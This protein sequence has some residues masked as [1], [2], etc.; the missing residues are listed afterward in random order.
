MRDKLR[1]LYDVKYD[2]GEVE[3]NVPLEMIQIVPSS[4]GRNDRNSVDA[5][6]AASSNAHTMKSQAHASQNQSSYAVEQEFFSPINPSHRPASGPAF[7]PASGASSSSSGP[8]AAP[9]S[10][11]RPSHTQSNPRARSA[12]SSSAG[13]GNDRLG[14]APEYT[15]NM[16]TDG[17][18]MSTRGTHLHEFWDNRD[19]ERD[20]ERAPVSFTGGGEILMNS[21]LNDMSALQLTLD[22]EAVTLRRAMNIVDSRR[23]YTD[24]LSTVS[25]LSAPEVIRASTSGSI[26]PRK[27]FGNDGKEQVL[28]SAFQD[29]AGLSSHVGTLPDLRSARNSSVGSFTPQAWKHVGGAANVHNSLFLSNTAPHPTAQSHAHLQQSGVASQSQP[30]KPE[31]DVFVSQSLAD[32]FNR[33]NA[34]STTTTP[35]AYGGAASVGGNISSSAATGNV[36]RMTYA[37]VA[38]VRVLAESK[39][40]NTVKT[41]ASTVATATREGGLDELLQVLAACGYE[42][43][44]S[45]GG[46]FLTL[47]QSCCTADPAG[48]LQQH[49]S[50]GSSSSGTAAP[51]SGHCQKLL[52]KFLELA[53]QGQAVRDVRAKYQF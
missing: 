29:S 47:S 51:R 23:V 14:S 1:G 8:R 13:A 28:Y 36:T 34:N 20:Q 39:G 9:P 7:G 49:L 12:G 11:L 17:E 44:D 4:T 10:G 46:L 18:F 50:G 43:G 53:Q 25:G 30:L 24:H 15:G 19:R 52:L 27:A 45:L 32:I 48:H 22:Q 2:D 37:E 6:A 31:S 26:S 3:E 38:A 40:W 42:S 33:T 16:E 41:F 21:L 35:L 5:P